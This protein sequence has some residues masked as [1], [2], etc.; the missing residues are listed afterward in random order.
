VSVGKQSTSGDSERLKDPKLDALTAQLANADPTAAAAK[1]TFQQALQEWYTQMP[2][3]P[4]IKTIYTHQAN[5][6]YWEGWPT[7]DNLFMVPNS[8]WGQFMFVVG[9]LKPAGT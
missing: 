7:D 1:P 3:I 2:V 5:T 4:S 9:A 6:T 8:W